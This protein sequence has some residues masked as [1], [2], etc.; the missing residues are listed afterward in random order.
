MEFI[1]Q[2][3]IDKFSAREIALAYIRNINRY[4]SPIEDVEDIYNSLNE[5]KSI[6]KKFKNTKKGKRRGFKFKDRKKI[7]KYY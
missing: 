6:Q 7:K 5:L 1:L 4:L 2:K 3:I